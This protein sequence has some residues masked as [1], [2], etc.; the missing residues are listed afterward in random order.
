MSGKSKKD[1]EK[2]DERRKNTFQRSMV[3]YNVSTARD[4][5]DPLI[6]S[7]KEVN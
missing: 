5:S 3:T 1:E 6:Q 7:D 2:D 4:L